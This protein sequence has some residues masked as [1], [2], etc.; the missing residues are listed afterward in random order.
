[1]PALRPRQCPVLWGKRRCLRPVRFFRRYP[2]ARVRSACGPRPLT[3]SPG[4][5]STERKKCVARSPGR[6]G[7]VQEPGG[8]VWGVTDNHNPVTVHEFG[9]PSSSS[10]PRVLRSP[11]VSATF[12]FPCGS[13]V[14]PRCVPGGV[15]GGVPGRI[16][17]VTGQVSATPAPPKSKVIPWRGELMRHRRL[18]F[19]CGGP[20]LVRSRDP[21]PSGHRSLAR[22]WRGHGAGVAR[23][24]VRFSLFPQWSKVP[25]GF[26]SHDTNR[27]AR[28]PAQM[29]QGGQ[30]GAALAFQRV[31][32]DRMCPGIACVPGSHVSRDRMC[33]GIACVPGSSRDVG[34]S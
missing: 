3:I 7:V 27:R 11:R 15:P 30:Q 13:Q 4:P 8:R 33:P 34:N 10:N 19:G 18:W 6:Y 1:M 14:G 28:A 5:P 22:A 26:P 12:R 29:I 20:P 25:H 23:G 24:G 2:A 21:G 31:S 9:Y 16:P 32:R 17:G